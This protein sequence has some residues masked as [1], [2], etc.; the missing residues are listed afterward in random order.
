M[1]EEV[2]LSPI[3]PV[4]PHRGRARGYSFYSA[5]TIRPRPISRIQSRH[6]LYWG[7][8]QSLTQEE[9]V[10]TPKEAQDMMNTEKPRI[11]TWEWRLGCQT[12]QRECS[13]GPG[14]LCPHGRDGQRFSLHVLAHLSCG[15]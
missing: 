11:Y 1:L 7:Q 10:C 14:W 5:S 15:E 13:V 6:I 9:S 4:R 8:V 12:T 2:S 3:N